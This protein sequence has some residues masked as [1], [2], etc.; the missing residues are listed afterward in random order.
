LDDKALADALV[1][2]GIG[3]IEGAL[4]MPPNG[5][6]LDWLLDEDFV[7]DARV[8]MACMAEFSD[9]EIWRDNKDIWWFRIHM[10]FGDRIHRNWVCASDESLE[11]AI[12][13]AFVEATK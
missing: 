2:R 1:E 8:A 3:F 4:Y 9:C 10:V 12:C 11:R 6:H 7:R 13:M 5:S